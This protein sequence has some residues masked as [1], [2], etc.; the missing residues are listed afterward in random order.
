MSEVLALLSID[1]GLATLGYVRAFDF[2][3]NHVWQAVTEPSLISRWMLTDRMEFDAHVG[4]RVLYDWGEEGTCTGT[5]HIFDPPHV[6]EYSWEEA[7]GA[8]ILRIDLRATK[9]GS[10][11]ELVHRDLPLSTVAGVGPGWHTHLEYL[12]AVLHHESF[13]FWPRF[14]ELEP[15]YEEL[16]MEH[17]VALDT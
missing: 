5:V 6:V 14:H 2:D 13:D 7:S 17:G 11:L 15:L 4:G 3:I 8:S 10:E 9:N 16:L 1:E 12:D